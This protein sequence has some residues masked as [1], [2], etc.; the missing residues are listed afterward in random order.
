MEQQTEPADVVVA[1]KEK[2][3]G[4]VFLGKPWEQ[5]ADL[6]LREGLGEQTAGWL[7]DG[8]VDRRT[9][10]FLTRGQTARRF[11]NEAGRTRGF[12]VADSSDFECIR[13]AKLAR[14]KKS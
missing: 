5:H 8:F 14:E 7:I 1:L 11:P 3:T 10:E 4:R 6:R 2:K 9:G 12:G 13:R